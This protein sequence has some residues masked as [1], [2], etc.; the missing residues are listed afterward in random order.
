M[1]FYSVDAH[2]FI[3]I[4]VHRVAVQDMGR[5]NRLTW[6]GAIQLVCRRQ[7]PPQRPWLTTAGPRAQRH[8]SNRRTVL[9]SVG[10]VVLSSVIEIQQGY[11]DGYTHIS[12]QTAIV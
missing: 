5:L 1:S 11:L 7:G 9:P 2:K 4:R 8:P 6:A 12:T 3:I 10:L